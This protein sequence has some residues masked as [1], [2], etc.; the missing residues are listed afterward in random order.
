MVAGRQLA[1]R[2]AVDVLLQARVRQVREREALA[3]RRDDVLEVDAG[4][5]EGLLLLRPL[6]RREVAVAERAEGLGRPAVGRLR[7]RGRFAVLLD[8]R[9]DVDAGRELDEPLLEPHEEVIDVRRLGVGLGLRDGAEGEV[10][11]LA[12][13]AEIHLETARAKSDPGHPY[14]LPALTVLLSN[15]GQSP[16]DQRKKDSRL[17]T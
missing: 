5:V 10:P 17:S 15:Y 9:D 12:L 1:R 8:E 7:S 4:R 11:L 3:E 14:I 6:V 13:E 2:P 16:R